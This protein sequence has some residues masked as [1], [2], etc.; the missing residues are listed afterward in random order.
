MC[1]VERIREYVKAEETIKKPRKDDDYA[2][3]DTPRLLRFEDDASKIALYLP[4]GRSGIEFKNVELSYSKVRFTGTQFVRHYL[5]PAVRDFSATAQPGEHIGIIGRTGSGKSSLIMCLVGLLEP[6]DGGVFLDGI[7]IH[8]LPKSLLHRIIGVFPQMSLVLQGW[9]LRDF[10]D[11][12]KEYSDERI[13]EALTTCGLE[14]LYM[15]LFDGLETILVPDPTDPSVE[16]DLGSDHDLKRMFV[17]PLSDYQLRY[18]SLARLV[19]NAKRYRVILVDEPPP[20]DSVQDVVDQMEEMCP[21]NM[22]GTVSAKSSHSHSHDSDHITYA[23]L[24]LMMKEHFDHC[25]VF[26]VAHHASSLK[27]CDRVWLLKS[28]RL[29]GECKPS[30][31][32]TQERLADLLDQKAQETNY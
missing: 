16:S 26:V 30:D 10:M 3:V 6:T 5:P 13:I 19:L 4:P 21:D 17:K 7:P 23:P 25:T 14:K 20:E 15:S 1:S 2:K 31:I 9:S 27:H 29:I 18:V 11:P 28:G 12:L 8:T 24:N 22:P 32:T